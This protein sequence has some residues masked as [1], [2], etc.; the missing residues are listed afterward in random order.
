[1]LE[2]ARPSTRSPGC[3]TAP[4]YRSGYRSVL[5]RAEIAALQVGD[6]H[7]NCGYDSLRVMGKGGRRDALAINPQ[8]AA[9]IR[10]YLDVACH[11]AD[12]E[13]PIPAAQS[14]TASDSSSADA[15][16]PMQLIVSFANTA[17]R[18]G[19]TAATRHTRC[20]RPS[21]PRRSKT[22]PSSKTCRKAAGHR[23][24][25]T[26]KLYDRRG[27]NNTRNRRGIVD[28]QRPRSWPA[29][30]LAR[31]NPIA[32]CREA[33]LPLSNRPCRSLR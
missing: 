11:S 27:Y 16:T 23:D 3:A 15:L 13:G 32:G 17:A 26:T 18:S 25:G 4:S 30:V 14:T 5:R 10:A 22:G 1:M 28:W 29:P 8:T 20:A 7:Q 12:I 2:R 33:P 21:L 6:L 31:A 24:P 19:S 9:R